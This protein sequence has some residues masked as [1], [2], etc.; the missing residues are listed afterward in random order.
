VR[1]GRG[2]EWA[3]MW[4]ICLLKLSAPGKAQ[5]AQALSDYSDDAL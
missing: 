2:E 5:C 4:W 1:S 3:K